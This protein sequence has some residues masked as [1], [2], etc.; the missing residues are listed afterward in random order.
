MK[1]WIKIWVA[2]FVA[3]WFMVASLITT[4][5]DVKAANTIKITLQ[6]W[7]TTSCSDLTD[8]E[9]TTWASITA[10]TTSEL[11]RD[12]TCSFYKT[13]VETVALK[14]TNV[15]TISSWNVKLT[16]SSC[17]SV[18]WTATSSMCKTNNAVSLS[19][20]VQIM[21]KTAGVVWSMTQAE[22]I[23]VNIPAW[24]PQWVYTG[25]INIT[26]S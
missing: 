6:T 21:N 14:S 2:I 22:K 1:K 7:W 24:T 13:T 15:G 12:L 23:K 18:G 17:S 4:N 8:Y 3:L 11:S 25:T 10:Q 16:T 5:N 20:A 26:I 19:W 9:W